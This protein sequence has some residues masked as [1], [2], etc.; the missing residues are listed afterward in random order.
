MQ[1]WTL[2]WFL[3]CVTILCI[4]MC[5]K[6]MFYSHQWKLQGR[7][8]WECDILAWIYVFFLILDSDIVSMF[9]WKCKSWLQ[10]NCHRPIGIWQ[11]SKATRLFVYF[12]GSCRNDWEICD[13]TIAFRYFSS[14]CTLYGECNCIGFGCKVPQLCQINHSCCTCK[15]L[16]LKLY[17]VFML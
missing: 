12:E 13:S 11:E 1:T 4:L 9:L 5:G 6:F 14:G 10:I 3:F 2:V 15:Y 8:L 7:P 16:R 17:I